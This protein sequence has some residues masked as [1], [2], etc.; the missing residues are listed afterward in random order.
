MVG[1]TDNRGFW[2]SFFH[3]LRHRGLRDVR[4][5]VSDEF[6]GLRQA[7]ATIFPTAPVVTPRS[8]RGRLSG[9]SAGSLTRPRR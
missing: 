8:D 9:H 7:V 4:A 3:D 2:L 6:R 1:P 5:V